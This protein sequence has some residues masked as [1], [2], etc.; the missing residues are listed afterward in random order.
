MTE[1]KEDRSKKHLIYGGNSGVLING[2]PYSSDANSCIRRIMLRADGIEEGIDFRAKI[3]FSI[4][5][6]IEDTY[7]EYLA[8]EG[9]QIEKSVRNRRLLEEE[10]NG[11]PCEMWDETDI[12][13]NGVPYEVKSVSSTSMWE[14]IFLLEEPKWDNIVQAFHHMVINK[15]Y[16]GMLVYISTIYHK[17]T[18]KKENVRVSAGDLQFFK[19]EFDK[20]TGRASVNG[21]NYPFKAKDLILWQHWAVASLAFRDWTARTPKYY[22]DILDLG[23]SKYKKDDTNPVCHW[24]S[25]KKECE[26]SNSYVEFKN[27]CEEKVKTP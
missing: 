5:N 4:G 24:C 6:A 18:F 22:G 3:T 7:A 27:K 19:L 23:G 1:V 13:V 12:M 11:K 8:S 26:S 21:R 15:K 25:F 9:N 17:K 10:L 16:E 20:K 2:N 14:K